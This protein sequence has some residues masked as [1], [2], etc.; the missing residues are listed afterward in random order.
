MSNDEFLCQDRKFRCVTRRPS[1]KDLQIAAL[2][3]IKPPQGWDKPE[4]DRVGGIARIVGREN[5]DAMDFRRPLC[6]RRQRPRSRA[7]ESRDEGAP[8]HSITSSARN[9]IEVGKVTSIA[10]AVLRLTTIS[11]LVGGSIGRSLGFAPL[12]IRST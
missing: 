8:F 10:L 7:A 5:T 12:A 11:N 6:A 9:K 4:G 1:P 3:V 2:D